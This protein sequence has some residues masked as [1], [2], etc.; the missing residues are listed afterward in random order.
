MKRILTRQD[1][2][3]GQVYSYSYERSENGTYAAYYEMN[4]QFGFTRNRSI[5]KSKKKMRAKIMPNHHGLTGIGS[6][7]ISNHS[8]HGKAERKSPSDFAGFK[9]KSSLS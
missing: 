1:F 7:K 4:A 6:K 2:G 5:I 3:N 9:G 8:H